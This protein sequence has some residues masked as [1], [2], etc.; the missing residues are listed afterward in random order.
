MPAAYMV[1]YGEQELG[2]NGGIQDA[3]GA[4]LGGLKA[5]HFR[6]GSKIRPFPN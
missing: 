6:S 4:N 5:F 1:Q 3:L 2:V